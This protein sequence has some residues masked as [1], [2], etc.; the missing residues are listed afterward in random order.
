VET[1]WPLKRLS[2][3]FPTHDPKSGPVGCLIRL[4]HGESCVHVSFLKSALFR[5]IRGAMIL[6]LV[7]FAL[8]VG[9][10][11]LKPTR[12]VER[13][14]DFDQLRGHGVYRMGPTLAV[15]SLTE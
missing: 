1:G 2:H 4:D 3:F 9:V 8:D 10:H 7:I 11:F 14:C 15:A 13:K 12:G 5:L 6:S